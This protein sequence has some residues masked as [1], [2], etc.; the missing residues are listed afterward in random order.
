MPCRNP[1]C[2]L[3]GKTCFPP[4]ISGRYFAVLRSFHWSELLSCLK[5]CHPALV[6]PPAG[7]PEGEEVGVTQ[8]DFTRR[9]SL[10]VELRS[11]DR[12]MGDA[13]DHLKKRG[14]I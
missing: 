1:C 13:V 5:R 14:L 3:V 9:D 4:C 12:M 6:V 2:S 7:Y 10:G 8:F 11:L